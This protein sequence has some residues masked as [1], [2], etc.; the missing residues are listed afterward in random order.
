MKIEKNKVVTLS[1]E[2]R[3]NDLSGTVIDTYPKDDPLKFLTGASNII[4]DFETNIIGLSSGDSF[5]FILQPSQAFGDYDEE[6]VMNIP[7]ESIA[8]AGKTQEMQLEIGHPIKVSDE[9]GNEMIGEVTEIDIAENNVT[10]DFNHPF[11]GIPVH[12][13][14]E[15]IEVR[16]ATESEIDHGHAH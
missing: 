14:G 11:A 4:E 13:A 10:V 8:E 7:Y 3:E 5:D 16:D 1:C 15:I 12:F 2:L 6:N 9:Q